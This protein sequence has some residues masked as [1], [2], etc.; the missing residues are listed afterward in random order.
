MS[1]GS[2][3]KALGKGGENVKKKSVKVSYGGRGEKICGNYEEGISGA[4]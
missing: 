2:K 4:Q 3:E 1:D